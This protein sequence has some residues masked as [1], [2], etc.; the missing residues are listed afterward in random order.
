MDIQDD[1]EKLDKF[2]IPVISREIDL[3]LLKIG[4]KYGKDMERPALKRTEDL[5]H[6]SITNTN[7]G[8]LSMN[9]CKFIKKEDGKLMQFN[10]HRYIEK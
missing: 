8:S 1:I 2:K 4:F 5:C 9:I 6:I 7:S 10:A 3:Y